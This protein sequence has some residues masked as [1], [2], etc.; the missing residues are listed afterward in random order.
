MPS[1]NFPTLGLKSLKM[2]G[3]LYSPAV[4]YGRGFV[5]EMR[6]DSYRLPNFDHIVKNNPVDLH[7]TQEQTCSLSYLEYKR[8]VNWGCHSRGEA[9]RDPTVMEGDIR[10]TAAVSG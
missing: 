8:M 1:H 6:T 10:K 7:R 4:D 5:S 9:E 3:C 2:P